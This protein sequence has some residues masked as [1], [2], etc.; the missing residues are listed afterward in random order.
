MFVNYLWNRECESPINVAAA[1]VLLGVYLVWDVAS[2]EWVELAGW[3]VSRGDTYAFLQPPAPHLVLPAEKWLLV[4]ALLGFTVGYRVGLTSFVSAML[5]AHLATIMHIYSPVGRADAMFTSAYLLLFF[6]IY[7]ET[8]PLT[9]DALRSGASGSTAELADRI[10][11]G[12][13]RTFSAIALTWSLLTVAVLYFG[14]AVYKARLGPLSEW[15]TAWNL[16]RLSILVQEELGYT[17]LGRLLLD[18]PLA[19]LGAAWGTVVL[20]AGFLLAVLLGVSITPV[21]LGL[22]GTHTVIALALGP[23][24]LDQYVFLLLF[25]SWNRLHDRL[26]LDRPLDVVY[27]DRCSFCVRSVYPFALLDT[28]DV[29]TVHSRRDGAQP[30]GGHSDTDRRSSIRVSDGENV[31]V[32][33]AAFRELFRQY[34]PFRPLAWL[35]DLAPV[36]RA[37][38]RLSPVVARHRSSHFADDAP[39]DERAEPPKE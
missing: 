11:T 8:D 3:H 1:R 22:F 39:D 6:G 20:E 31:Y 2:Y 7:R 37:G 29:L 5:L 10:R 18:Y 4:L 36:E 9:V 38:T 26:A 12:T 30:D 34:G 35:M 24:F 13:D 19:L 16:G 32:G 17:F 21:V 28:K 15:A 27:D 23:F 33:Y 25:V 14:S